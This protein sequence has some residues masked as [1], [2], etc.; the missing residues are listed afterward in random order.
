MTHAMNHPTETHATPMSLLAPLLAGRVTMPAPQGES[1]G[2]ITRHESPGLIPIY[3]KSGRGRVADDITAEF[4]RLRWL[5]RRV[6][7]P[8]VQGFACAGDAATLLTT[9][10]PGVTAWE[11]LTARPEL[12]GPVA[13]AIGE[14]L[15]AMHALPVD[16]CPFDA[17]L[18]VRIAA[19]RELVERGLVDESDFAEAHAGWSARQVLDE[20]EGALPLATERVV[21]HGDFSLG[22]IM[23]DETTV[24]G[25]IDVGRVGVA[26]PYQD[27]AILH[28]SLGE[29]GPAAQDAMWRAYSVP[30]PDPVRLRVHLQLDELF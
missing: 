13:T 14:F 19:A 7:C 20:V 18:A 12:T 16:D 25:I 10:M 8:A 11:L 3:G 1:G 27:L 15:R 17:G 23:M 21:T 30:A 4:V 26:D 22:N 5:A 6:P 9:A 28:D 2:H 29:F 24:T